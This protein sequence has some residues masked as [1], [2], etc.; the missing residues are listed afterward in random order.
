M[1]FLSN[2]HLGDYVSNFIHQY[3]QEYFYDGLLFYIEITLSLLNYVVL[4]LYVHDKF[5]IIFGT[6]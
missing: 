5:C 2:S 6:W 1:F 4:K 3:I